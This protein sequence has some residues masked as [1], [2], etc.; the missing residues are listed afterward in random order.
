MFQ[1]DQFV[2]RSNYNYM[3]SKFK[4][5][6][7]RLNHL[8]FTI[9]VVKW[10][11]R[12]FY[13]PGQRFD[14]ARSILQ[15]YHVMHKT[16]GVVE[17]IRFCKEA[18]SSLL[19]WLATLEDLSLKSRSK[20]KDL[21]P[22]ILRPLA[23][24]SDVDYP[25]IRLVFSALYVSRGEEV[26]PV[27]NV[28]NII[29]PPKHKGIGHIF[30]YT[31]DFWDALGVH[32]R[33][34]NPRSVYWKKFH[35]STKSGPNGQSL[36]SAMADLTVLPDTLR[37]SIAVVG[38]SKLASRMSILTTYKDVLM[39]YFGVIGK[40]CRK[41]VAIPSQEGKTREVA[42]L[43]YWSQT[44]LKGLHQY[45][46]RRLKTIPQ[47]CT[48]DQGSFLD[49][50]K[51]DPNHNLY[52]VDLTAATDRFPIL[53]IEHVLKARFSDVYVKSW[54]DIMVGY[55]FWTKELGEIRYSVGNPM[56]AYSSWNSFALSHH[57]VVYY[58]C[59]ELGI[60]W[61]DARYVLLGDDIVINDDQLAKKYMETL[62][63][64]GVEFS[65]AKTHISKNAYEFAKRIVHHGTE[66]SPFPISALWTGR[67]QPSLLLNV[68]QGEERKG[69]VSSIGTPAALS[70]L[71][72]LLEY[73]RSY[74]SKL[75][76]V[77]HITY[78]F[79]VVLGGRLQAQE[80]LQPLVDTY[81]PA[82]ST[83]RE[84]SSIMFAATIDES[85][86]RSA[87]PGKGGESLGVK[88]VEL[89]CLI[90]G[91]DSTAIDAFDLVAALP[92]LQVHGQIEEHY[93]KI[94]R[95]PQ[96]AFQ[97]LVKGDWKTVL[98]ALT[99]P[100]SDRIYYM[101]NQD[102]MVQASFS[103][104]KIWMPKMEAEESARRNCDYHTFW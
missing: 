99:I 51:P 15:R 48:F 63:E 57:Y 38:G 45:L 102:L 7:K 100:L 19:E 62:G 55:P 84:L 25:F 60:N 23:H 47:D 46:F 44:A 2:I 94:M 43:D 9:A 66:V 91:N 30:V 93:L 96:S 27:I 56:G 50:L 1:G 52:S 18:R 8:D 85:F 24:M 16:R 22:K 77:M 61:K 98:K 13:G 34:K 103:L 33:D 104:A 76:K 4:K 65:K 71:Y 79:M 29:G 11:A 36:W 31:H 32:L 37:H 3:K 82:L 49:K 87:D 73:S 68:L 58:C 75:L 28:A 21:L 69:W 78:Q 14:L 90:T 12:T 81:Y 88:A 17:A 83:C 59:R 86:R 35:L 89:V 6:Y 39:P 40:R 41:I 95:N 74:R 5:R 42:I 70:E 80:A 72:V 20:S 54:R 67:R 53:G 97:N 101:R 92:V 64:L 10:L 26:P